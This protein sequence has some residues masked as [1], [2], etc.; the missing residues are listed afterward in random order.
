MVEF[1]FTKYAEKEF[2]KL[3]QI[4][5]DRISEKLKE[6]KNCENIFPFLKRLVDFEPATHRLRIGNY[7]LILML[8]EKSSGSKTLNFLVLDVGHRKDIYR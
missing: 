8:N 3:S 6:L 7:R 1:V 2:L 5:R 4:D